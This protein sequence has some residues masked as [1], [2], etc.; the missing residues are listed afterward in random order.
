MV[1]GNT[2]E[3]QAASNHHEHDA[4]LL[5]NTRL[6]WQ[7]QQH[8]DGSSTAI[9]MCTQQQLDIVANKQER[10]SWWCAR[11]GRKNQTTMLTHR[12]LGEQLCGELPLCSS[13]V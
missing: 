11:Q 13:A 1:D 2:K 8:R 5:S 4:L 10:D 7:Q 3:A 12:L 6:Q 9:P